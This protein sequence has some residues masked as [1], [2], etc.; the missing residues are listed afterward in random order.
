MSKPYKILLALF[1]KQM[2]WALLEKI[3]LTFFLNIQ[4]IYVVWFLSIKF[5][6]EG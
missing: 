4:M 5:I 1:T 6:S 2:N 3:S